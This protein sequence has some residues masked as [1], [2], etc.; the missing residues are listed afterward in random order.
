MH[1]SKFRHPF[2]GVRVDAD[3]LIDIDS[4]MVK[5]L[6]FVNKSCIGMGV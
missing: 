1:A 2:E 4:A 6:F 3:S 5:C